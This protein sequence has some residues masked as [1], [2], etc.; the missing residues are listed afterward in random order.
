MPATTSRRGRSSQPCL[1]SIAD[2]PDGLDFDPALRGQEQLLTQVVDVD[3]H[4]SVVAFPRA[5]QHIERQLIPSS[6]SVA[7]LQQS[8]QQIELGRRKR[9]RSAAPTDAAGGD[10]DL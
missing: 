2:A 3:V 7:G 1:G 6:H 8:Y 10:V 9:D 4:A 5:T